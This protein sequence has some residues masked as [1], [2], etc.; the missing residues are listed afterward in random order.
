[1]W[2]IEKISTAVTIQ[3]ISAKLFKWILEDL[4]EYNNVKGQNKDGQGQRGKHSPCG[5]CD[6]AFC[7][8][9]LELLLKFAWSWLTLPTWCCCCRLNSAAFGNSCCWFTLRSG[10]WRVT[11]TVGW[12]PWLLTLALA[13]RFREL[14]N[15]NFY[16]IFLTNTAQI[17]TIPSSKGDL[18]F[19]NVVKIVYIHGM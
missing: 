7:G 14:W 10:P 8:L 4:S 1:M 12:F 2:N 16:Y 9:M 15:M 18:S 13:P 6:K 11:L 3:D 5:T 19:T 17:E